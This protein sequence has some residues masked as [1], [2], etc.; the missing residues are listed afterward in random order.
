MASKTRTVDKTID[1]SKN[2]FVA[3]GFGLRRDEPRDL[4]QIY[5]VKRLGL[6]DVLAMLCGPYPELPNFGLFYLSVPQLANILAHDLLY[7]GRHPFTRIDQ[8]RLQKTEKLRKISQVASQFERKLVCAIKEG[9]LPARYKAGTIKNFLDAKDS[10]LAPDRTY[11]Y[12]TDAYQWLLQ[13]GYTKRDS[14]AAC[15]MSFTSFG[16]R[17]YALA[18]GIQELL[19]VHRG[20]HNNSEDRLSSCED[21]LQEDVLEKLYAHMDSRNIPKQKDHLSIALERIKQLEAQLSEAKSV[22]AVVQEQDLKPIEMRSVYKILVAVCKMQ[23]VKDS[24]DLVS[25]IDRYA[26][27]LNLHVNTGTI[28]S[29][30]KKVFLESKYNN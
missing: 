25:N 29:W 23:G 6:R 11:I 26:T 14:A 15:F 2:V 5:P 30:M 13:S 10:A 19:R 28:R 1:K 18:E 16:V 12:F 27:A 4:S 3:S 17:E 9:E 7:T 21:D 24:R 22:K 20:S 8:R